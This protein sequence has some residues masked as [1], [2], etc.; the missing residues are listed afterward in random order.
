MEMLA[1]SVTIKNILKNSNEIKRF[2]EPTTSFPCMWETLLL[3]T[4]QTFNPGVKIK[5]LDM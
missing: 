2:H 4:D 5:A 3:N 1:F